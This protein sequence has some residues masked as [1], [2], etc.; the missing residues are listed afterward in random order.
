M[1]AFGLL[2]AVVG[3]ALAALVLMA[4]VF[5]FW[6]GI[7]WVV[8]SIADWLFSG[9]LTNLLNQLTGA[10]MSAGDYGLLAGAFMGLIAL[11]RGVSFTGKPPK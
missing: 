11:G 4:L 7:G 3:V 8:A 6:V 5:A 9:Y 1:K 10:D 2:F